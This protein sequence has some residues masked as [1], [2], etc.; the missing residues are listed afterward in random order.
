MRVFSFFLLLEVS[1]R[2]LNELPPLLHLLLLPVVLLLLHGFADAEALRIQLHELFALVGQLLLVLGDQVA[3]FLFELEGEV[4]HFLL[5]EPAL[6][7]ILFL[8]V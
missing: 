3:V 2:V 8:L 5:F 1:L 6:A 4:S 7:L